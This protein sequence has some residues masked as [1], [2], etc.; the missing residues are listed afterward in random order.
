MLNGQDLFDERTGHAVATLA[1]LATQDSFLQNNYL[2][3]SQ[4]WSTVTPLILPGFDDSDKV[5]RRIKKGVTAEE[6]RKLLGE[7]NDR[8][9]NLIWKAFHNAGFTPD[10]LDGTEIEYRKVGWFQKLGQAYEYDLPPLHYP[11]YHVRVRFARPVRGPLVVGAG[12]YRGFG[13]FAA[14]R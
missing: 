13:L 9:L 5:F 12:R 2:G 6:Q 4:T 8:V 11:R 1:N 3:S 7:L 14:E 10:A